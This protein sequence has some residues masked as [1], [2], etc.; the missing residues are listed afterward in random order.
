MSSFT[1]FEIFG[2]GISAICRDIRMFVHVYVGFG[3]CM[4]GLE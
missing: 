1:Q 3:V 4:S 2:F